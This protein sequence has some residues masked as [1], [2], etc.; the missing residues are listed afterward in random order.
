[1][2]RALRLSPAEPAG[3]AA[4]RVLR[5]QLAGLGSEEV[6]VRKGDVEGIHDFRVATRRLRATLRLFQPVLPAS[7]VSRLRASLAWVAQAIGAVRDLDVLLLA[8]AAR[9]KRLEPELRRALAPVR[10]EI[11]GRRAAAHAHL[12]EVVGS[13]RYAALRRRLVRLVR[14]VSSVYPVHRVHSVRAHARRRRGPA[15]ASV[16]GDLLGPVWQGVV[17]A[18]RRLHEDAG[19]AAYHR[20]RVRVKRLRYALEALRSLHGTH[21]GRALADLEG[22]QGRLGAVQDSE[23]QQAWLRAYADVAR[24]PPATLLAIGAV[25]QLLA[26]RAD[27]SR[28]RA[29][30][31]WRRFDRH[32]R[33]RR[34]LGSFAVLRSAGSPR[35][36]KSARTQ[37]RRT[38]PLAEGHAVGPHGW[39]DARPSAIGQMPLNGSQ[40]A[41][42]GAG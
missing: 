12:L 26:R 39:H 2:A 35:P 21:T 27:R 1:V 11:R 38:R 20:L 32:E 29:D 6:R 30:R 22:L 42:A 28:T 10:R 18:G 33:D 3:A 15:L 31:A 5:R 34:T 7:E 13:S 37:R 14:Q 41:G 8:L 36:P 9:A 16:A 24:V 17:H 23:T 40:D 4:R 25:M 19:A